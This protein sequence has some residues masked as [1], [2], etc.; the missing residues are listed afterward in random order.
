[1]DIENHF[2]HS[3]IQRFH[4]KP[5]FFGNNLNNK[6][7]EDILITVFRDLPRFV[8][9]DDITTSSESVQ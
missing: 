4:Y 8:P 2:S 3:T 5:E 1:M 6:N 9:N 7:N